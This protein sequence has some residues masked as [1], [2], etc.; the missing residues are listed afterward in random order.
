MI[1]AKRNRKM[2]KGSRRGLLPA[3]SSRVPT[4]ATRS[5][6]TGDPADSI[7]YFDLNIEKVLEFW[8]VS[9]AV[10][11]LIANALDERALSG[12]NPI[13]IIRLRDRT[14]RIRDFGRGLHHVHFTQNESPEKRRRESEVIGRFGVGLKDA[15]AVLDRHGVR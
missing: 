9:H 10:R 15:L 3:R 13:E 8:E 6:R 4:E 1:V 7:R 11:E 14:W 5:K 2:T 12:T